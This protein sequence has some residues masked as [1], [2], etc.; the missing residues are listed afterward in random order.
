VRAI[1]L[2]TA[3]LLTLAALSIGA[4]DRRAALEATASAAAPSASRSAAPRVSP[5]S[6]P[7]TRTRAFDDPSVGLAALCARAKIACPPKA[8]RVVVEKAARALVLFDGTTRVATFP[9]ALGPSPEGPKLR[10]GDGRTPEGKLRIVTRNEKSKYR[11]F[12]GLGYPTAA[13]GVRGVRDGLVSQGEADAIARA[14]RERTQ[15]PW[16]TKL[17]GAV[18]IHG[19]GSWLDW[20]AGCVAL[21]DDAIDVVW[22]AV[23]MGA[24]VEILP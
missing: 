13:D 21:D 7:S 24:E 14:E 18:G 2:P 1:E 15:P 22:A 10:E 16:G 6:S 11:R 4:C 20:T 3:L 9:I 5:S 8:P 23:P 19:N 17:G 12:L